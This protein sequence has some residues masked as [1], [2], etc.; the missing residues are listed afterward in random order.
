MV[1]II[2]KEVTMFN[3]Y[4]APSKNENQY[5]TEEIPYSSVP[6]ET[7]L[8]ILNEHKDKYQTLLNLVSTLNL[9]PSTVFSTTNLNKIVTQIN[10]HITIVAES[11]NLLDV[12][13]VYSFM[14]YNNANTL[15]NM[16]IDI[17]SSNRS[18]DDPKKLLYTEAVDEYYFNSKSDLSNLLT[19]NPIFLSVYIISLLSLMLD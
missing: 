8:V 17:I 1:W 7:I 18:M 10:T 3:N 5:T 19:S 15:T 13:K 2:K 12:M 9:Y 14:Y 6:L 11:I 16:L 4:N